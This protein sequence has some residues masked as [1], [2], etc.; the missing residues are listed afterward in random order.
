MFPMY[1]DMD[2]LQRLVCWLEDV[3]VRH[4]EIGERKGLHSTEFSTALKDYL[5]GV[6]YNGDVN[7]VSEIVRAVEWLVRRGIRLSYGDK[8][9]LLGEPVDVWEGRSIGVVQGAAS[10]EKVRK[11]AEDLLRV[12]QVDEKRWKGTTAE[13]LGAVAKLLNQV[14]SRPVENMDMDKMD[15]NKR[16][17]DKKQDRLNNVALGFDEDDDV[18][19]KAAKVLRLLHVADLRELQNSINTVIADMQGVTSLPKTNAA[20]G[21]VGR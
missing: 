13:K 11:G 14:V 3:H 21:R 20:L 12:L 6:G 18:V 4:L 16:T 17:E 7:S 8:W 10:D 2:C 19:Q 9:E 1:A 5:S 15:V